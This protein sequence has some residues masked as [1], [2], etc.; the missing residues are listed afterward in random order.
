MKKCPYCAE[1]IQDEA[2]VCRF[3]GRDLVADVEKLAASRS[4]TQPANSGALQLQT[5]KD[6]GNLFELWGKSNQSFPEAAMKDILAN[7]KNLYSVIQP[8]LVEYW[9][10]DKSISRASLTA[11]IE[12]SYSYGLQWACLCFSVGVEAGKSRFTDENVPKYL[13][14]ISLPL[15]NYFI[16]CITNLVDKKIM[17]Q[18]IAISLGKNIIQNINQASVNYANRG[19]IYASQVNIDDTSPLLVALGRLKI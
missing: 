3:C 4:S 15:N 10:K 7:T 19:W 11:L 17:K 1:S 9:M 2:I 16:G 14:A 12:Q 5:I 13:V 18:D 6:L 8:K